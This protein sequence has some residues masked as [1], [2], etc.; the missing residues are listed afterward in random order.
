MLIL[1]APIDAICFI[2]ARHE[3]DQPNARILDE[4]LK[5]IDPIVAAP[6]RYEKRPPVI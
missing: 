2:H 3:E 1:G 5:T 6:V 4:V